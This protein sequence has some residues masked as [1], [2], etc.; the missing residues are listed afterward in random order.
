MDKHQKITVTSLVRELRRRTQRLQTGFGERRQSLNIAPI[1]DRR[2]ND[3]FAT[4]PTPT[5]Y[6]WIIAA[7]SG[8]L[9][10]MRYAVAAPVVVGQDPDCDLTLMSSQVSLQHMRLSLE[11][12]TLYVEDMGSS[13]GTLLNGE[14]LHG[15][16]PLH[17]GDILQVQDSRF[18]V[19]CGYF[20]SS[21]LPLGSTRKDEE[22]RDTRS[23][24][25]PAG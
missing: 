16:Q 24:I 15:R 23:D 20:R 5:T 14:R 8:P 18:R 11:R 19:S 3:L 17:H 9:E 6:E 22:Q 12:Y 4:R 25:P 13:S 1:N 7:E 10:G 21:G 2:R